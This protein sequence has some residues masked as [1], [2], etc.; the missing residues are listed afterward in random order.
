MIASIGT[1]LETH[2]PNVAAL[3]VG[4]MTLAVVFLTPARIR[5]WVPS[6]LLALL[7]VTPLSLLLFNDDRLRELGVTPL[8]RIGS[9]P[10]GGLHLAVP[11]FREHWPTLLRAG[12]VLALL[13]AIDSLLT[14]LVA[15]NLSQTDHNSNRELIGQGVANIGAGLGRGCRPQA[16]P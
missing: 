9:I 12:G 4:C 13:G 15:D 3:A 10:E 1:L 5:Q 6:P 11:N 8:A 14:S 2:A 16:P 7:I